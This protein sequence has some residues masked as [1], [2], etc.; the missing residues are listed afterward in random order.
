MHDAMKACVSLT[1]GALAVLAGSQCS[2]AA[3]FDQARMEVPPDTGWHVI[4]SPYV[5][6]ASLNGKASIAGF[7]TDVDVPFL[8][9]L[10]TWILLSNT[11]WVDLKKID[12]QRTR[13]K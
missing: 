6:G 1:L 7:N 4:V 2:R 10:S 9:T 8:D 11:F 3:D 12:F 5:W 13:A